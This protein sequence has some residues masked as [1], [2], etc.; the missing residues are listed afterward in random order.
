MGKRKGSAAHSYTAVVAADLKTKQLCKRLHSRHIAIIDHPDVDEIA[1]QSLL[2]R[3]VK[4]VLNLSP[5][6]TGQYPAEGARQLLT[7]GVTL[8]EVLDVDVSDS[9]MEWTEGKYAT[10]REENLYILLEEKWVHVC[11][12]QQ[13]TVPS[14][15]NR[16]HEAHDKLD[17]TL[18]SFIDN[19][20]LYAS[21]EKDLFLKPLC[22]VRL[23]TKMEQRHVIV[24]VRGKHYKEDLLTLS[25]YI[26]E[27]RPVLIGVDGGADA[28][29]E[30]GYRPDLIVGD[31]DSV[32]D[33]ALQSGAEIVVHAFVNGTAP[34]TT[35]VKALGLPY[36]V[37]PAPGT[38]EDVAML[39]AYEKEAQLI[40][41]IGAHTNMIDFLEKGRKGMASTLLVRTKIGTK[42][43]DAKGVSHLYRPS[44]SWKLWAW[45]IVAM[46]LPVSAALVIN[47]IARHAV[48]MIWTQWRTWTL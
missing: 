47:P 14:I 29:M 2:E 44:E 1:A 13:V 34:G 41:T 25:S 8:Y 35:R 32:S 5:F 10:I 20:L 12:L 19:T 26:R 40:V 9:F 23:H 30:A 37:L 48:Q 31:M 42:L 33:R 43:I 22:H 21:K 17:D 11:R 4:V 7:N 28:L 3:G 45:C 36:H 16:W 39:L 24:V 15:L 27:Y 46:L 18:S 38:S 6:M